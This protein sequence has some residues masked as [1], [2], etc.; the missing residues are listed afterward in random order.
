MSVFDRKRLLWDAAGDNGV[1]TGIGDFS[2]VE[3]EG[4]VD[5]SFILAVL[6][7]N[8]RIND[9][10]LFCSHD[11]M[12]ICDTQEIFPEINSMRVD[13]A[14]SSLLASDWPSYSVS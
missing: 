14:F 2:C 4:T 11:N 10:L 6:M 3:S 5:I 7:G 9:Q 8:W 12:K 1:V 13:Q